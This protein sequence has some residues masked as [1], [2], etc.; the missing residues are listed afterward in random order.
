MTDEKDI[1]DVTICPEPKCVDE[2]ELP[3]A[4]EMAKNLL[5][6]G[7]K[8]ISNA[9]KGNT[10]LVSQEVRDTRWS[11]CQSCPLLVNDRCTSCG[12]FMKVKVAFQTSVCP[13]GKW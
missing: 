11:T 5:K 9:V 3:S 12:C 13:E 1:I 6:D 4:F 7:S 2:A 10:T 8:I